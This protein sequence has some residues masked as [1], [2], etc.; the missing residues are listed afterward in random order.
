MS[1]ILGRLG[2][3]VVAVTD[4]AQAL[5]AYCEAPR[6]W[7]LVLLDIVM[8]VMCGKRAYEG[9]RTHD[10]ETRVLLCSGHH[11]ESIGH[12]LE[13]DS[14]LQFLPK[15]FDVRSLEGA[16]AALGVSSARRADAP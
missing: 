13:S 5:T 1:R 15:P 14:H 12:L 7:D 6:D 8:P 2:Y 9:I 11:D 3:E 4:G 10:S 16:L